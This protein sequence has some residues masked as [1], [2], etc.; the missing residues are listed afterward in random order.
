MAIL[1]RHFRPNALRAE[2]PFISLRMAR[3]S[4]VPIH[5][6]VALISA[7]VRSRG[8]NI[9]SSEHSSNDGP[10]AKFGDPRR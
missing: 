9:S 6:N 2:R 8:T 1:S 3:Y 4:D 5:F 10:I 7:S